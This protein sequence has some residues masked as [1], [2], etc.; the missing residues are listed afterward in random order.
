MHMTLTASLIRRTTPP[1]ACHVKLLLPIPRHIRAGHTVK[2]VTVLDVSDKQHWLHYRHNY[3]KSFQDNSAL[4]K[5]KTSLNLKAFL[6][7]TSL[8]FEIFIF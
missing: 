7:P 2:I 6:V 5:G 3:L 1:T 8:C 4:K